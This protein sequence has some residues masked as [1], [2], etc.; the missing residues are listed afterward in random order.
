MKSRFTLIELL[1][2]IS[3]IAILVALL[4][5]ALNGARIAAS[6]IQCIA[7]QKQ[8]GMGLYGYL[9]DYK[10]C[11]PYQ[12]ISPETGVNSGSNL[13]F[14]PALNY[15]LTGKSPIDGVKNYSKI[16][17]CATSPKKDYWLSYGA[18]PASTFGYN[19]PYYDPATI[20]GVK[21]PS[22]KAALWDGG[23][24]TDL[25]VTNTGKVTHPQNY[26]PGGIAAGVEPPGDLSYWNYH[27]IT[28]DFYSGRHGFSVNVLF[29]DGHV[30]NMPSSGKVVTDYHKKSYGTGN[31]YCRFV[32]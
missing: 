5:P 18:I 13:N 11:I 32:N 27:K 19:A 25:G 9:A 29:F 22:M 15:E 24:R 23:D 4:L 3:I 7:N 14:I 10:D 8:I 31:M 26:I 20:R 6:K 12:R 17:L 28:K 16:F 2:V 21:T 1:V 30:D